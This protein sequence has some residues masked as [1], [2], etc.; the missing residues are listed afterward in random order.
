MAS[1][2]PDRRRFVLPNLRA[3]RTAT[4]LGE[5]S[6]ASTRIPPGPP[7]SDFRPWEDEWKHN[8]SLA[9]AGDIISAAVV[10]NRSHLSLVERAARYVIAAKE[11][12]P[13]VLL[14]SAETILNHHHT[15]STL[16]DPDAAPNAL[17]A[18]RRQAERHQQVRRLKSATT[19]FGHNPIAFADLARLYVVLGHRAQALRCM[20][21]A[22]SLAPTSRYVLR[23]AARLYVHFG[24]AERGFELLYR[25]PR[26][27][28]D[29][30]LASATLALSGLL[31][32]EKL[33]IHTAR[34]FLRSANYSPLSLT[35]LRAGLG[36]IELLHGDRRA[37]K[38]LLQTALVEPNDNS[39][40][41]VE[42]ALAQDR[43]FDVDILNYGVSR[44]YE[45]LAMDAL[46]RRQWRDLL[47]H[48]GL[49]LN[50]LPYASRPALM[51]AHVATVVLDDYRTA[52][53]FCDA[54]LS[55]S[56]NDPQI[57]NMLAY[58]LAL[59]DQPEAALEILDG[60]SLARVEDVTTRTCLRATRGLAYFRAGRVTEGR[61]LYLEAMKDA[62]GIND[63]IWGQIALLNYAR[64][65]CLARGGVALEIVNRVRE[66]KIE[67]RFHTTEIF[68]G[69]VLQLLEREG[70]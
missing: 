62:Q 6:S 51:A 68:K 60:M 63:P 24:D 14:T 58:T 57:K 64:E 26:T 11:R 39:L 59:D 65:E 30:W 22:V 41:Q 45:A 56:A 23:S 2:L 3:F 16:R 7:P 61:T 50:D 31:G 40:A 13:E 34:R 9:L 54:A 8:P 67:G 20:R 29:P 27:P 66:L 55:V 43:L 12:A 44:Q 5:V 47:F 48:C 15:I 25:S 46:S 69:K 36:S 4:S 17:L 53:I 33:V 49:W 10:S 32:K 52:R 37:S 28:H 42:W 35:E 18:N 1:I 19:A 21:I 38:R 70:R